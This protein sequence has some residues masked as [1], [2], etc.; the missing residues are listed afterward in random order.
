MM[1]IIYA[2]DSN[3]LQLKIKDD[4]WRK[5]DERDIE[6]NIRKTMKNQSKSFARLLKNELKLKQINRNKRRVIVNLELFVFC[7]NLMSYDNV[8]HA[9]KLDADERFVKD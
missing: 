4:D 8:H 7:Y 2:I 5:I 9:F 6:E 1:I 3:G